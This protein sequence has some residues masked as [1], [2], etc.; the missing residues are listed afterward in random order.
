[1]SRDSAPQTQQTQPT[2]TITVVFPGTGDVLGSNGTMGKIGKALEKQ[3]FDVTYAV[4]VP[5]ISD[6]SLTDAINDLVEKARNNPG[7]T[8]NLAGWSKGAIAALKAAIEL[9]KIG[10]PVN[11]LSMIDPGQGIDGSQVPYLSNTDLSTTEHWCSKQCSE[12]NSVYTI[13]TIN[14]KSC[15][16]NGF[17]WCTTS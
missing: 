16:A 12:C 4:D 2:N 1:M 14:H 10:V 6:K 17:S 3:G 13:S 5:T 8:V 11:Q 15:Y 7:V 9:D